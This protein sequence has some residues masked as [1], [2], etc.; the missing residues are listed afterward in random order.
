MEIV[1]VTPDN[2]PLM[3][4]FMTLLEVYYY[5]CFPDSV[6]Y[7]GWREAMREEVV[8][9]VTDY[10]A[11]IWMP[12]VYKEHV[13]LAVFHVEE[14]PVERVGIIDEF[15]IVPAFRRRHVG[16]DLCRLVIADLEKEGVGR[17]ILSTLAR[18]NDRAIRFWEA[19]GFRTYRLLMEQTIPPSS[20]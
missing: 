7:D 10:Q 1:N 13:G 14:N 17:I 11:R 2:G 20:E 15:Y 8:R 18:D 3:E 4:A 5:E 19:L 16:T 12:I 9:R 6:G